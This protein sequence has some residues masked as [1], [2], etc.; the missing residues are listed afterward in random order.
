LRSYFPG[1]TLNA[2]AT[3]LE[4]SMLPIASVHSLGRGLQGYLILFDPHAFVIDRQQDARELPSLLVF[5]MI[6]VDFTPTPYVPLSSHPLESR[7]FRCRHEVGPH[8][9]TS[10]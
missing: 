3:P 2:L 5:R 6:S 4:G 10:D 7:R 9:F 1:D 8:G